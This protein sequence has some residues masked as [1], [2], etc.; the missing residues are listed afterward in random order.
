MIVALT[1]TVTHNSFFCRISEFPFL[2]S[3]QQQNIQN[4][5]SST[6]ANLNDTNFHQSVT[7]NCQHYRQN[8]R[9]NNA[10]QIMSGNITR[11]STLYT[12]ESIINSTPSI[13]TFGDRRFYVLP[14]E[15][16]INIIEAPPTYNDAL[17][18]PAV[19]SY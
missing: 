7:D 12:N 2:R 19:I 16:Q 13:Q 6:I 8:L 14:P 10:V 3:R 11:S 9:S 15:H 4:N 17:K 1:S 5:S 18:H